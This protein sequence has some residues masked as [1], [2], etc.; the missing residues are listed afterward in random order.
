MCSPSRVDRPVFL[1]DE[2]RDL[3]LAL[4]DHA[5]R[6]AL[7]AA[8]GEAAAHFLPQQRREIEADEVVER[9]A[10]LLRVHQIERKLARLRHGIADRV[11]RD[12]V[13]H[14][15]VHFLAVELAALLEDLVQVPGDRLAL[16]VRV[17]R[18]VERLGFL[19]RAR[20]GVD[21]ALVL[22]EHLVL[23][24]EAVVGVDRAFLRHQVAHVAIGGEHLEVLAEVLLDGLRLGRRFDDDEVVS[25]S[26]VCEVVG[27]SRRCQIFELREGAL[28]AG[29]ARQHHEHH[30]FQLLCVELVGIEREHAVDDD[31]AL[32]RTE[33]TP[34]CSSV[35][36]NPRHS[37]DSRASSPSEK[38]RSAGIGLPASGGRSR[39]QARSASQSSARSTFGGAKPAPS[40]CAREI[41]HARGPREPPRAC[42]DRRRKSECRERCRSSS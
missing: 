23:H 40:R 42:S 1:R 32:L 17:G 8:G 25:H 21:V 3:F 14:H 31:L 26:S 28:L 18:Q 9:A 12:L 7:H 15:A 2:R 4:A 37:V 41:A 35:K 38:T 29:L 6:G 36:R 10:R 16:A 33:R 20:D 27:G 13:E 30:P 24:G 11:A 39:T 19:Q 5:Q 22:L 34:S